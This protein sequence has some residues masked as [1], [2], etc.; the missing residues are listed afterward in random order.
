MMTEPHRMNI[1]VGDDYDLA[2]SE[3]LFGFEPRDNFSRQEVSADD[4]IGLVLAQ[5]FNERSRIEFVE[6]Q[7]AAFVLPWR[8]ELV[9]QPARY[10]GHLVHQVDVSFGIQMAEDFVGVVENVDVVD[11]P[12]F[13]GLHICFLE[14]FLDRLS[15][16]NVTGTS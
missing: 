10:F 1:E 15:S 3:A 8:I 9:I 6:S 16:A 12:D 4:H 7:A 13:A 5:E 11:F 2:T 14:G